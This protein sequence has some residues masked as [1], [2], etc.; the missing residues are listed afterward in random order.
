MSPSAEDIGVGSRLSNILQEEQIP[1]ADSNEATCCCSTAAD[2]LT[3]DTLQQDYKDAIECITHCE[4]LI[5]TLE[6]QLC[7]K[8]DT[9]L[10]L[11]E[12]L[13]QMSLEL[14]SAKANED[15]LEISLRR[16]SYLDQP[17][18]H[19]SRS[20]ERRCSLPVQSTS[21]NDDDVSSHTTYDDNH[22]NLCTLSPCELLQKTHSVSSLPIEENDASEDDAEEQSS[23]I[24]GNNMNIVETKDNDSSSSP[25]PKMQHS[26]SLPLA[27]LDESEYKDHVPNLDDTSISRGFGIGNLFSQRKTSEDYFNDTSTGENMDMSHSSRG[28]QNESTSSGGWGGLFHLKK[29]RRESSD[30]T[31]HTGIEDGPQKTFEEDLSR[32]RHT[33]K[34]R[35]LRISQGSSYGTT[36]SNCSFLSG[37]CFPTEDDED[38]EDGCKCKARS[39][40]RQLKELQDQDRAAVL[41]NTISKRIGLSDLS[42]DLANGCGV[43]EVSDEE[44]EQDDDQLTAIQETIERREAACTS[45]ATR[46]GDMYGEEE[47]SWY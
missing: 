15:E 36:K 40:I 37:V 21:Y 18:A 1:T 34:A 7:T 17:K 47:T 16:T 4:A 9:I 19:L 32:R 3:F 35:A 41:A 5:N 11:E 23:L 22:L 12:R 39:F 26:K 2:G 24:D 6:E 20:I 46:L 33:S 28:G 44:Q 13:V 8:D 31:S 30:A 38:I 29:I 45:F 27:N 42:I 25:R 10:Q 43:V 14:A